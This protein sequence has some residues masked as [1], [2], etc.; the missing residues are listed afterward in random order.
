MPPQKRGAREWVIA[1]SL[2]YYRLFDLRKLPATRRDAALGLEI[3]QWSPFA[4]Y[5][6][7]IVWYKGQ[8]QVWIWPLAKQRQAMQENAVKQAQN[9]PESLLYPPLAEGVRLLRCAEGIE[10]Q[11]W[12]DKL[13]KASHWW[14]TEPSVSAWQRFLRAQ[15]LAVGE[16]LPETQHMTWLATP[17]AQ[18]NQAVSGAVALLRS[19]TTWILLGLAGLGAVLVWESVAIW[20]TQQVLQQLE[21]RR[22]QLTEQ[23]TPI[24]AARNRALAL[25]QETQDLIDFNRFPSQLELFAVVWEKLPADAKIVQWEYQP[26]LLTFI[27]EA[28]E[29]D[30]KA[31]AELFQPV[32]QFRDVSA[33]TQRRNQQQLMIDA[34]LF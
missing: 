19:E 27:V 26:G 10:G 11:V 2:C 13:L 17:W 23:A 34:F 33:K 9:L 6:S 7:Y 30:P 14:P 22:E 32:A 15:G 4:A 24:L 3:R 12:Q 29:A 5:A 16:Q 1:R 18:A 25:Q 31:Y 21:S 28:P 20:K 8:A